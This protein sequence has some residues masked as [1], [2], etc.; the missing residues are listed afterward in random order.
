M[1][2][3][4]IRNSSWN[5]K[6]KVSCCGVNSN[7]CQLAGKP[8][9]QCFTFLTDFGRHWDVRLVG[10]Q[11]DNEGRLEI[12]PPDGVWGT[13]CAQN[14]SAS[15]VTDVCK[16]PLLNQICHRL[17]YLAAYSFSAA[18]G[19]RFG[20]ADGPIWSEGFVCPDTRRQCHLAPWS[21]NSSSCDHD[22]DLALVCITG[23]TSSYTFVQICI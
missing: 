13:V 19:Q 12:R 16:L 23:D 7:L 14:L 2:N 10:G 5:M 3:E 17:G 15:S 9:H 22:S 11:H 20:R 1:W 21:S 6:V 8:T 18:A 4:S